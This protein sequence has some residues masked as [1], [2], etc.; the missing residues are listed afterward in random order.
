[1][2]ALDQLRCRRHGTTGSNQLAHPR[3]FIQH[4]LRH[5]ACA[6]ATLHMTQLD[7]HH[8]ALEFMRQIAHGLDASHART[9]LERVQ[10]TLQ[11][12]D[13]TGIVDVGVPR[14]HGA[15]RRLQQLGGF[16]TEDR[17]HFNVEVGR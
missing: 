1:M 14:L 11:L 8:Q 9:A 6:L 10:W 4:L 17:G 5:G 3:Q 15:L 16:F 2:D 13:M 12:G 7:L